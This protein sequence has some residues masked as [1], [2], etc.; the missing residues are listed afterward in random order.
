MSCEECFL[1]PGE[2]TIVQC[3][4]CQSN[5]CH[6]HLSSCEKCGLFPMCQKCF[7]EQ[8]VIC[9]ECGAC[10]DLSSSNAHKCMTKITRPYIDVSKKDCRRSERLQQKKNIN[11]RE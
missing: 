11:Y 1:K 9:S 6:D 8:H 7:D 10:Y 5:F 3:E 2:I 4:N